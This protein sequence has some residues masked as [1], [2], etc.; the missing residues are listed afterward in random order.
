MSVLDFKET[1]FY[2]RAISLG[3][4]LIE[5]PFSQRYGDTILVSMIP[6][7][8]SEDG[9]TV[10]EIVSK[11]LI[12][13]AYKDFATIS[14]IP[15]LSQKG[16]YP[17][18]EEIEEF[19]PYVKSKLEFYNNVV[20]FGKNVASS[21]IPSD[22]TKGKMFSKVIQASPYSFENKRYIVNYAPG[23]VLSEGGENSSIYEQFVDAFTQI[24][25]E[26]V[27]PT[28]EITVTALSEIDNHI[29]YFLETDQDVACDYEATSLNPWEED[30][31]V[32]G[33]SFSTLDKATYFDF[34]IPFNDHHRELLLRIMTRDGKEP[35][36]YNVGYESK[37]IWKTLLSKDFLKLNDVFVLAKIDSR[38]ESLKNVARSVLKAPMWE[39]EL[40]ILVKLFTTQLEL[41]RNIRESGLMLY[42]GEWIGE[43]NTTKTK[44]WISHFNETQSKILELITPDEYGRGLS[45][46]SPWEAVPPRIIGQYCCEDSY[47]TIRLKHH[48]WDQ[49]KEF[50]P[51]YIVQSWLGSV[52]ESYGMNWSEEKAEE[53]DEFYIQ[54][55]IHNLCEILRLGKF[56]LAY[57]KFDKDTAMLEMQAIIN[58]DIPSAKKLAELKTIF[59]P[60]SNKYESQ[61]VFWNA[62]KTDW[63]LNCNM[64]YRI[65]T[66]ILGNNFLS[67][68]LIQHI[69]KTSVEN[70][71]MTLLSVVT[72]KRPLGELHGIIADLEG[73]PYKGFASAV[74][75]YHYAS[76]TK[77]GNLHPDCP[78]GGAPPG[79]KEGDKGYK[80]YDK[81]TDEFRL[82]YHLR[83]FK[84]VAKSRS[85]YINGKVG[86]GKV[87]LARV[88]DF[89][90]PPVR[91]AHID[92]VPLDY[93]LK[94]NEL[95][96]MNT[97]FFVNGADTRRWRSA[98]HC[99]H[100]DTELLLSNGKS[101]KIETLHKRGLN[102]EKIISCDDAETG[103]GSLTQFEFP[104]T[105][106]LLSGYVK[107]LIELELENGKIIKC[108]PNHRFLQT[109]GTYIMAKDI[110]ETTDLMEVDRTL[111]GIVKGMKIKSK[112]VVKFPEGVAVYDLHINENHPCFS[113]E[114][115]VISHNT[116]PWNCCSGDT[117]VILGNGSRVTME[118]LSKR[119][120][121]EVYEVVTHH[122]EYGTHTADAFGCRKVGEKETLT[123]ELENGKEITC[124]PDHLFLL[125]NGSWKEAGQLSEED[126]LMEISD[127]ETI[128]CKI[129]NRRMKHITWQH[130]DMHEIS[131]SDY[132]KLYGETRS[133]ASQVRRSEQLASRKGESR[134]VSPE[135]LEALRESIYTNC[136]D[137]GA[138]SASNVRRTGEKRSDETRQKLRHSTSDTWRYRPRVYLDT[139][140]SWSEQ[141]SIET[142]LGVKTY[143]SSWE[144]SFIQGVSKDPTVISLEH[145]PI[146]IPYEF[147]GRSRSYIPDFIVEF[148][149]GE[150]WLVEIKPNS[151]LYEERT[152]AKLEAGLKY[153]LLNG[154]QWKVITED[155]LS[156]Y[157]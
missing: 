80:I 22:Y 153:A 119:P 64:L 109:N 25:F 17:T 152:Q 87:S 7:K 103:T 138:V 35:W 139:M 140:V 98:I 26:Y 65:E 39:S 3:D 90:Q 141:G 19:I 52:M 156:A 51:Y 113:L 47:W 49:Y 134:Y 83:K 13:P 74:F 41:L 63:T 12:D 61:L 59:N 60:M 15:F 110:D 148:N 77:Y 24:S 91:I 34:D 118:E 37:V 96:L 144:R 93:K 84:K 79:L 20:L 94:P 97:D 129:C 45:K 111:T 23:F 53:L 127:F 108:T 18:D 88:D 120:L 73:S 68:D 62:F 116:V 44:G 29:Q 124:T 78:D 32:I 133:L 151:Y 76:F 99:L 126:E 55:G 145:E 154:M 105:E 157:C 135:R 21:F 150:K 50:Y 102:G 75:E 114:A 81:W 28:V 70:T 85:S 40:S 147:D 9:S 155:T 112:D 48:Y 31:R 33:L 101:V 86:R 14:I 104:I 131:T 6:F 132:R 27:E 11:N 8:P 56:D 43:S 146:V 4:N 69:D 115:G 125:T 30:F 82:L 122:D 142:R 95:F 121:D 143:R 100:G 107:E 16:T 36:V 38:I 128:E 10:S 67:D 46:L 92:Q 72:E 58:D 137:S 136:L 57:S 117:E 123:I 149:S 66:G 130:L 106:V 2:K 42:G 1:A 71:L 89:M 5:V 54:E